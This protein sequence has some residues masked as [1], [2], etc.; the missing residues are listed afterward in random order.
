MNPS[1]RRHRPPWWPEDEPWPPA[2]RWRA[3]RRR[4]MRRAVAVVAVLLLLSI[5]GA[6]TVVSLI[7][8][9]V[10]VAPVVGGATGVA[11][12]VLLALC[13]FLTLFFMAMRRVALPWG[14]ILSAAERAGAGD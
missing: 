5:T 11:V 9:Q 4:A 13:A 12:A 2:H 7:V 3:G 8:K 6:A 14:E 10:G 1:W